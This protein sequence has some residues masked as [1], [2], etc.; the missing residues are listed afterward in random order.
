MA[1]WIATSLLTLAAGFMVWVVL[2]QPSTL[3]YAAL[4]C[5]V[6]ADLLIVPPLWRWNTSRG[7]RSARIGAAIVLSVI[8]LFVPFKTTVV[9]LDMPSSTTAPAH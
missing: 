2:T 7:W 4:V 8:F 1:S 3:A 6:L 5:A 9:M